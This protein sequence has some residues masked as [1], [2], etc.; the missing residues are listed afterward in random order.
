MHGSGIR[1]WIAIFTCSPG[2]QTLCSPRTSLPINIG[3]WATHRHAGFGYCVSVGC[4]IQEP[5]QKGSPLFLLRI[6]L[7]MGSAVQLSTRSSQHGHLVLH[8]PV[9]AV[10]IRV[11][12]YACTR[13]HAAICTSIPIAIVFHG[14]FG[15]VF[16][17]CICK[18]QR[19]PLPT[20]AGAW[21]SSPTR[22][23][24]SSRS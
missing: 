5:P 4:R 16:G 8:A 21:S 12:S 15:C 3:V 17:A 2:H 23:T 24:A 20:F 7:A 14:C 13:Y 6:F 22:R 9:A 19:H 10:V 1:T 18:V 11:A